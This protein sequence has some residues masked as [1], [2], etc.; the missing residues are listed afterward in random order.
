MVCGGV[1]CGCGWFV[2]GCDFDVVDVYVYFGG[3]VGMVVLVGLLGWGWLCGVGG[4]VYVD[5]GC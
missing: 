5:C 4:L 3:G 1:L 2:D